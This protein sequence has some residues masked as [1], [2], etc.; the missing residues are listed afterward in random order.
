MTRSRT[1]ALMSSLSLRVLVALIAGLLAGAPDTPEIKAEVTALIDDLK[2]RRDGVVWIAEHLPRN[3]IVALESACTVF[4]CPSIYEPL[5]IVNLEAMACEAAVVATATGGIPE[6]IDDGV[7]GFLVPIDQVQDGTGT[8]TDPDRYV[9]DL[10][11][12]LTRM[13]ADP[14]AARRMGEAGRARA[15]E[16][17][18]WH[19]IAAETR[20][21]YQRVIDERAGR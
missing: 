19:R 13:V 17:F 18:D 6:V 15:A 11:D 3:E 14:E 8:P 16:H 1:A 10:A 12:A 4:A 9:A 7:T 20:E 21:V 5:G 2:T